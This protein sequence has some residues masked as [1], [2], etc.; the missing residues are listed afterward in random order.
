MYLAVPSQADSNTIRS[1]GKSSLLSVNGL[2][3]LTDSKPR[4]D[5]L[6]Q[7]QRHLT[8]DFTTIK[9]IDMLY[10]HT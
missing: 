6:E 1:S 4:L 2:L 8:F 5:Y 10:W 3:N 7:H 9:Y